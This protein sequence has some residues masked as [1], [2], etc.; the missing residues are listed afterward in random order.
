MPGQPAIPARIL[1]FIVV[2]QFACTSLWFAGN[3]VMD[4]L[5]LSL[6]LAE[7]ALG[8]LT[9]AVQLGFIS[10]T[11][12]FAMFTISDRFS[13][14]RVFFWSAIAGAIFNLAVVW[15]DGLGSLILLRFLTGFCLAGVYPVGMK[16]AYDHFNK[17]LGK[18]LGYLVG[19]LV[20]GTALPHLLRGIATSLPW[21]YVIVAISILA[22]LGGLLVL[23]GVPDGPHRV[24]NQGL[25][26]TAFIRLFR[27]K[28]YRQ[29][30]LGYFGHMWE[31]YTF[32]AFLPV[33]VGFYLQNHSTAAL[34]VSLISFGAIAIGGLGC[35]IGGYLA[36]RWGSGATAVR[37]LYISMLCCLAFPLALGLPTWAFVMYLLIWGFC[38]VPDS[39]QFSTLAARGVPGSHTG[40]ALTFMNSIGFAITIVSIQT[41][42]LLMAH[43]PQP[44]WFMVL[45]LGP[46]LGL[47]AMRY[48]V[49]TSA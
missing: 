38:V 20:V 21:T 40:T 45:A 19:A 35:V 6:G 39:P 28:S 23:L 46:A 42:T 10:G 32:W 1:P 22:V 34:P 25:D 43:N 3:G 33:M 7:T 27:L 24:R 17:N 49:T 12:I 41:I 31:L 15:A 8:H 26:L 30:A 5:R 29:P 9:S 4:D 18:A 2:A 48:M 47:W 13:P 14:S 16:L 44:Y 11:L 36:Q 37:A